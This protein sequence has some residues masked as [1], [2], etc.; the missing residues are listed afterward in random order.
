M[1]KKI[2]TMIAVATLCVGMLPSAVLADVEETAGDTVTTEADT[3]VLDEEAEDDCVTFDAEVENRDAEVIEDVS[4]E[5]AMFIDDLS[6]TDDEA[7]SDVAESAPSDEIMIPSETIDDEEDADEE[8][9]NVPATYALGRAVYL[10]GEDGDDAGDGDEDSPVATFDKAKELAEEYS[11]DV[12]YITG[13]VTVT[14]TETWDGGLTICRDP[15]FTDDNLV[16]VGD[17]GDLTLTDITIDG[18]NVSGPRSLIKVN[19]EGAVLT[20]DD[21]TVIQNNYNTSDTLSNGD[22]GAVCVNNGKLVVKAGMVKDNYIKGTGGGV[23]VIANSPDTAEMEFYRGTISDNRSNSGGGIYLAG[24]SAKLTMYGG[25]VTDNSAVGFGGGIYVGSGSEAYI[26]SGIISNNK[27]TITAAYGGGGIYVNSAQA[28]KGVECPAGHLYIYNV[29]ISENKTTTT[30]EY[31]LENYN[32]TIACCETGSVVVNVTDGDVIHDN[33][34]GHSFFVYEKD[35]SEM[36]VLSPIM[37]GGGAYNWVDKNG[38]PLNLDELTFNQAGFFYA[39]TFVSTSDGNVTGLDRCYTKLIGNEAVAMGSAI[40][41]N[42]YVTIGKEDGDVSIEITKKWDN[43]P[44][45]EREDIDV[46]VY[47]TDGSGLT[48]CIGKVT[49][50]AENGWTTTVEYLPKYDYDG[51]EFTYTI[52]EA[53]D[54][55]WFVTAAG[56]ETYCSG[57]DYNSDEEKTAGYEY[58]LTNSHADQLS[59]SK[60]VAGNGDASEYTFQITLDKDGEAYSGDVSATYTVEGDD[61]VRDG[62]VTFTDG[63]GTVNIQAGETATLYIGDG[64]QWEVAELTEG[65][66]SVLIYVNGNVVERPSD[67]TKAYAAVGT[68]HEST[69]VEFINSYREYFPI[70]EE[71]VTD[72]DEI[73]NREAWVKNESVNEYNAI[74]IEMTTNLPVITAYDLENGSYTMN[75]HEV[76]DSELI[77]DENTP[78]FS[79]YIAGYQISPIYYTVTFDDETGDDCNF[80]VVVDLTALYSDGIVTEDML[81]GNTEITIFFFADLEGTGL[82]GTYK[83]TIWYDV[84]D[85]EEILYTSNVDVV[86]VYTYEIEILK[87][88]TSTLVGNDYEGSALAGAIL[89]VYYDEDCTEPVYR[90]VGQGFDDSKKRAY[91]VTSGDDGYAIFYGLAEGTYYVRE[92]EAP[93]GYKISDEVLEAALGEDLNDAGYAFEGVFANSPLSAEEPGPVIDNPDGSTPGHTGEVTDNP[94]GPTPNHAGEAETGDV[95]MSYLWII[96]MIAAAALAGCIRLRVK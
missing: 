89:G 16:I 83:S 21:G 71:I 62:T 82:N 63:T 95:N 96:L 59:V 26:Y 39:T 31:Y 78:D 12:V 29:E 88:D 20:I 9:E 38:D 41:N 52:A 37:L 85:G 44:E 55:G 69:Q 25:T 30:R 24:N 77:L 57:S 1:K 3:S 42:G 34:D 43:I 33:Y 91:T 92:T 80:H 75:F 14:D 22:Q 50:N 11:I 51:L 58:T 28:V 64:M 61:T 60:E 94:N 54:Y 56:G 5:A 66:D 19:G 53:E 65:A 23:G 13:P 72:T 90:Y 87:Y 6:V 47:A 68:I 18:D 15:D 4:D 74:E 79:V 27:Q 84:Y 46:C 76:L 49:L 36:F 10:N 81:D 93:S 2:L 45:D 73:F 40:G 67:T 86:Y 7:D 32:A 17:D 8:L 48:T 35:D 70:D